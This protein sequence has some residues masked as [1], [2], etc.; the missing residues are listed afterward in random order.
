M[1]KLLKFLPA[2][3]LAIAAV[4]LFGLPS[5]GPSPADADAKSALSQ[6]SFETP[7]VVE[8]FTSQG[9]SSC[10]PADA[11]LGELA[12]VPGVIALSMHVDYWDYIGWKDVFASPENTARQRRY[13]KSLANRYVYTP[14]MVVDGNAD[15]VGSR[16][17]DVVDLIEAAA[18]A[19]KPLRL[20]FTQE[21]GGAVVIPAGPA[22]D[23]GATVW[24]AVYDD[25]HDTEI[26]RGENSGQTL[27]YYNVVR[28][29]E[30]IGTWTGEELRLPVDLA[31][32]AA[33][34]RDGCA[35]I[36]Q[37]GASGRVLGAIAMNLDAT[38]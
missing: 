25:A 8:L 33:R 7:V 34:G 14:Q 4:A 19:A 38:N 30:Q 36:V 5:L 28:E 24:L 31:A 37:A 9:C 29:M 16:T 6:V 21:A 22:P 26:L 13:A 12:A 3:A 17:G 27:R 18:A 32:A 1:T 23:E 11:F 2:H 15:V 35:I 20:S 10:P